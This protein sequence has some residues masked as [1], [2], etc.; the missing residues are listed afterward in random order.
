MKELS[1]HFEKAQLGFNQAINELEQEKASLETKIKRLEEEKQQSRELNDY[2]LIVRVNEL[3]MNNEKAK[4]EYK[5][6]LQKVKE[7]YEK[8]LQDLKQTHET[9]SSQ[10]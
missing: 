1:L 5:R 2:E 6:D 9:V 4:D 10:Y 3:K 7:T 8:T